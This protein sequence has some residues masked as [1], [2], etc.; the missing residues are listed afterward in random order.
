M[1]GKVRPDYINVHLP[2]YERIARNER[3]GWSDAA[4]VS[5]MLQH[6]LR[7]LAFPGIPDQG[8]LLEL[9]CGDGCITCELA[10]QLHYEVHGVDIVP[11]AIELAEQRC[12][13]LGVSACF[14]VADVLE[15]PF[16]EDSF[17]VVIDA[18][19]WHC[20]VLTDRPKF[21]AEARR[22]LKP[23]GVFVVLTMTGSP[24]A[25]MPGEFD[26]ATRTCVCN[27]IAGR[28]FG[29]VGSL[30]EELRQG[31]FEIYCNWIEHAESEFENDDLIA[32]CRKNM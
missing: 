15:L 22:V 26:R 5:L 14:S 20:I 30:L 25:G 12:E 4:S 24:P 31:G 7:A 27:G 19:C 28:H 16:P 8:K 11:L 3:E 17:E 10:R 6:I 18:H 2:V 1:V 9:G 29:S 32:V 21:L 23:G 13:R